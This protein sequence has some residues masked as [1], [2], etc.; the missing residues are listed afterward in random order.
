MPLLRNIKILFAAVASLVVLALAVLFVLRMMH[1]GREELTIHTEPT[2]YTQTIPGTDI[3]FEMAYIPGG[4]FMIGSPES[5]FGHQPDESPQ[6]KVKLSPFWIGIYEVS[7]D[8]FESYAIAKDSTMLDAITLA[9]PKINLQWMSRG[10]RWI[11]QRVEMY[12]ND[13]DAVTRPSP[14]YGAYDHGMGRG[15]RPAIG[16]S[17]IAA[18]TYC[19]WLSKK[20]GEEYRLPTEAEWEYACRAGSRSA[21]C[22]GEDPDELEDFGWYEDNS[23]FLTQPPGELQPNAFGLYDMHGNVWEFC[24]DKYEAN[25]YEK[26]ASS[27]D[28]SVD[29]FN[30]PAHN[31]KAAL[32]GGSWD[33]PPEQLRSANRLEKQD[34]WNERDPQ[35]PRGRWWL[36]DA[37]MVGFRVVRSAK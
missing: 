17:W 25:Y 13:I 31:D 35:R 37:P 28:I 12:V 4:E 2:G 6:Q 26:L 11:S 15:E 20:T 22:F 16:M 3:S 19:E 29:P 8:E 30:E 24:A 32:R 5:E 14:Y 33:D 27:G 18:K 23:D 21:Y 9:S 10:A 36:V 1:G 34:W 7:W